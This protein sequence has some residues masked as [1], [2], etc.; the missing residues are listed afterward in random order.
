MVFEELAKERLTIELNNSD[1]SVLYTGTRRR[2]AINDGAREFAALT[3]CYVR[4]VA[5]SVVHD[6]STY[7]LSTISDFSRL[8][9]EG[10]VEYWRDDSNVAR[11][12]ITEPDFT[13]HDLV[14]ANRYAPNWR[15]STTP[16][17][18]PTGYYIQKMRGKLRIG[19]AEPPLLGSSESA[20]IYTP[21]V[22]HAPTMTSTGDIPYTDTSSYSRN[23]L[24]EYH[25]AFP[26]YAAYKLLPLIGDTNEAKE[27]L[28]KFLG[29]VARYK[30]NDR[31]AGGTHIT[32][33]QSYY[34]NSMRRGGGDG[35]L[36][37]SETWRWR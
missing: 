9:K 21:Y 13:R 23:D 33:A 25:A 37:R 32:V 35:A 30:E 27:Q 1:T 15:N 4:Y 28:Q 2:Q 36:D 18:F 29:Y 5:L 22:A 6:Q 7:T 20:Y 17:Q 14:W 34:K 11:T 19:L 26:H 3:E 10:Y 8:S 24:T 12:I 31:P 16:V